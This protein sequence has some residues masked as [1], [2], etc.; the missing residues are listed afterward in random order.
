[1][2]LPSGMSHATIEISARTHRMKLGTLGY[3]ILQCSA[4]CFPTIRT[5]LDK[6]QLDKDNLDQW[7]QNI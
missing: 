1:M 6:D 4:K 2:L 3:S 7:P 5:T